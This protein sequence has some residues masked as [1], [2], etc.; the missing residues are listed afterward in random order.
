MASKSIH[1][2]FM[3]VLLKSKKCYGKIAPGKEVYE[4]SSAI[5]PP[6]GRF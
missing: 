6:K 4:E 3:A 5:W 1:K 2:E